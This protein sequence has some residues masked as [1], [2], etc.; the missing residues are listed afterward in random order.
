MNGNFLKGFCKY[1]SKKCPDLCSVKFFF[2][3]FIDVSASF[4]S[5]RMIYITQKISPA[6]RCAGLGQAPA[7]QLLPIRVV[8]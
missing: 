5:K 4:K 6:S 1:D 7:V 2:R 8:V 3:K